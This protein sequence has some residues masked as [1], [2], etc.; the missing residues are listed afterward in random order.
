MSERLSP[1][2]SPEKLT[3]VAW[4]IL[5]DRKHGELVPPQSERLES[6]VNA[7]SSLEPSLD[8]VGI[9]EAEKTAE[10]HNGEELARL[11]GFED[12]YWHPHSRKDEYIGMFGDQ[13]GSVETLD[14][15]Y[16]KTVLITRIGKVCIVAVHL[17]FPRSA[18]EHLLLTEQ[19]Q[20][21]EVVLDRVSDEGHVVIM[22]DFN[23]P[24][25][26]KPRK[27]IEAQGFESVYET[28]DEPL[29]HSVLRG[30]YDFML[31][32]HQRRI[33]RRVWPLGVNVDDIYVKNMLVHEVGTVAGES[34]HLGVWAVVSPK[35]GV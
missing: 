28:L 12:S 25:W 2:S 13:V 31:T 33:L 30:E 20:Q 21:I 6:H 15:G 32:P 9:L 17:K 16:K 18:R 23:C 7:L 29:P 14:L 4:N 1:A 5:L 11:L 19:R 26:R 27:L 34:D 24:P 3:V 10:L 35:T 8:V 22:G